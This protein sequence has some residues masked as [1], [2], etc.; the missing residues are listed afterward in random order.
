QDARLRSGL[1]A[2]ISGR[3]QQSRMVSSARL[4]IVPRWNRRHSR[5][6][7][8]AGRSD[9]TAETVGGGSK[10]AAFSSI[11][12]VLTGMSQI[13][14]PPVRGVS[15]DPGLENRR[16]VLPSALAAEVLPI[17]PWPVRMRREVGAIAPIQPRRIHLAGADVDLSA[18][19]NDG[20][21]HVLRLHAGFF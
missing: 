7:G 8:G 11:V 18:I 2:V 20:D 19:R 14:E 6:I 15:L 3:A 10:W 5:V 13:P 16:R 1:T 21:L 9:G 17:R 4:R 12:R